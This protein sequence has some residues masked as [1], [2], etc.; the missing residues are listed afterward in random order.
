MMLANLN[1]QVTIP[2]YHRQNISAGIVHLGLGAFHRAH[3]AVYIDDL[4]SSEPD[5]GIIGVS[6]RSPSTQEA[7]KPQDNLY[8]LVE[9]HPA[10]ERYRIIGSVMAT[11]VAPQEREAVLTAMSD[12]AIRI[13][14]LTIT[15]KGYCIDPSSGDLDN[16]NPAIIADLANPHTPTTAPAFLIEALRRRRAANIEPF[17]V[18]S[19][20]NLPENGVTTRKVV[21]QLAEHM[22]PDL[23]AWIRDHVAFPST[24]VDRIVPAT[25]DDDRAALS[26]ALRLVDAW[27]VVAE[28]FSQ[29]V[30]ED[31]FPAGRPA[32][33]N[34]G[35]ELVDD[36]APYEMMKLRM[37][38]GSHS[39]LAYLG[40]LAGYETVSE[41]MNDD[42]FESF[43]HA[44]MTYE[45]IPTVPLPLADLQAYR[46]ALIARFKNPGL[47]H[48][49]SQIAMDGSQ[50]LPQRLLA[51]I[52]ERLAKDLPID[53]LALGVAAWMRYVMGQDE[54]GKPVDVR[55]PLSVRLRTIAEHSKGDVSALVISYLSVNEVFSSD[56]TQNK[57]FQL[58]LEKHLTN[59]LNHGAKA[60]IEAG[61]KLIEID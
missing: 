17:T 31:Y 38:N 23:A 37:L 52:K 7:L 48:R 3:Q 43:I 5:W 32:F 45:I 42:A 12:P 59:L 36:V 11:M 54:K 41:A 18:L 33:E 13:V 40:Y 30:V 39:T 46:D 6:L 28:P 47:Q 35:V 19:C 4:L 51:T 14:S 10:T 53:H 55:D 26:N 1:S 49:T 34:V 22:D 25:T 27:P 58:S 29:W 8:T 2:N 9:R 16:S 21:T 57:H 20:D 61:L 44:M 15:E 24:M 60:S 50:K 56:L